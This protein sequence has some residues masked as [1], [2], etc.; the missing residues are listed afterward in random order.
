M[1]SS[2]TKYGLH[3]LMHLSH[4]YNKGPVLIAELAREEKIPKKFLELILLDLK[5]HGILESKKGKGGGYQLARHPSEVNIGQVIRIL[6]GPLA[7]VSCV[8]QTAYKRCNECKDEHH[9]GIRL[10][11]KDVREAMANILDRTSLADMGVRIKNFKSDSMFNF[12]I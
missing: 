1:I 10:V 9:C 4:K 5:N 2:K 12:Q 11:M 8:S 3:A 6:D 7:P